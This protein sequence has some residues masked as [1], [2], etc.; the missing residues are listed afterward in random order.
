MN[1]L[2]PEEKQI[3]EKKSFESWLY[4]LCVCGG[5]RL[6]KQSHPHPLAGWRVSAP[7]VEYSA[8]GGGGDGGEKQALK[9]KWRHV[10]STP[11]T[12]ELQ[13]KTSSCVSDS[14]LISLHNREQKKNYSITAK[15][16]NSTL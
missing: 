7:E 6:V 13:P 5:G 10:M 1:S 15:A 2:L 8:S 3:E 12:N 14:V 11:L 4:L 9:A 16:E